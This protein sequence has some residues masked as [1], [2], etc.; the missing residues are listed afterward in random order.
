MMRPVPN[1]VAEV[2]F[3]FVMGLLVWSIFIGGKAKEASQKTRAL[4]RDNHNSVIATAKIQKIGVPAQH[5]LLA[6]FK[7]V[8]PELERDPTAPIAKDLKYFLEWTE[9]LPGG[10]CE[11]PAQSES[12][13]H[14]NKRSKG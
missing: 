5:C 11:S 3:L 4:V 7:D 14:N 8:R 9:K 13:I 12:K 10:K 6:I 1:I 2:L